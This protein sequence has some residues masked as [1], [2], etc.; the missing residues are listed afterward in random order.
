MYD[1]IDSL[2]PIFLAMTSNVEAARRLILMKYMFEDQLTFLGQ[3]KYAMPLENLNK[4]KEQFSGYFS[5][6]RSQA[7]NLMNG[8][9]VP[10]PNNAM[11]T[12]NASP[13]PEPSIGIK[14]GSIDLK[15]PAN[16]KLK[17][18]QSPALSNVSTP[19]QQ[20]PLQQQTPQQQPQLPQQPL[21]QQNSPLRTGTSAAQAVDLTSPPSTQQQTQTQMVYQ[22]AIA[23]G[24]PPAIV[25]LLPPRALQCSW[26]LQQ[27]SQNRLNLTP[28]QLQQIRAMLNERVEAAKQQLAQQGQSV[29]IQQ[30]ATPPQVQQ[31]PQ[32][33]SPLVAMV[34]QQQ[35]SPR[36]PQVQQQQQQVPTP[37]VQQQAPVQAQQQ[38]QPVPVQQQ[39]HPP[40][41]QAKMSPIAIQSPAKATPTM[42]PLRP[43]MGPDDKVVNTM[44][45]ANDV[46]KDV[47]SILSA[48]DKPKEPGCELKKVLENNRSALLFEPFPVKL[49]SS[50]DEEDIEAEVK[51]VEV[52]PAVDVSRT[53]YEVGMDTDV[54]RMSDIMSGFH[55]IEGE[56]YVIL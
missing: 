28:Q 29:T 54:P 35:A 42:T 18:N 5:W 31:Q 13:V 15:L 43:G 34:Q 37:V 20:L 26:L 6:V 1:K 7:P 4:L 10:A 52:E 3:N 24:L 11:A 44:M 36:Q 9:P 32:A 23:S 12:N 50:D 17:N 49:D 25:N 2:L 33:S 30:A 19:P 21:Q 8:S 56:G 47:A 38:Q 46:L 51:K 27:A 41:V 14:R 16:K 40:A 55:W 22:A 39:I 48:A 45:Y 53:W